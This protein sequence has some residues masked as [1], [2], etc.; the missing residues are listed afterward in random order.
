MTLDAFHVCSMGFD[1]TCRGK[2]YVVKIVMGHCDGT[3]LILVKLSTEPLKIRVFGIVQP[4]F[5]NCICFAVY[6]IGA[7]KLKPVEVGISDHHP[8][9]PPLSCH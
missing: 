6:W 1:T 2:P 5:G 4:S 3:T 7:F 9:I 8:Q